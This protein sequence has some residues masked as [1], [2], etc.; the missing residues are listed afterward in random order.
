MNVR[1]RGISYSTDDR[2]REEEIRNRPTSFGR[3]RGIIQ[4]GKYKK[5]PLRMSKLFCRVRV[6]KL[7]QAILAALTDNQISRRRVVLNVAGR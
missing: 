5:R 2:Q 1:K 3:R 7:R 6:L 4:S